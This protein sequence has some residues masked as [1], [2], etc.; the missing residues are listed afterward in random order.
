MRGAQAAGHR[1]QP[2]GREVPS[3]AAGTGPAGGV[4]SPTL[5]HASLPTE[6]EGGQAV[7]AGSVTTGEQRKGDEA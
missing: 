3:A 1:R 7:V 2:A 6:A 5:T 4:T